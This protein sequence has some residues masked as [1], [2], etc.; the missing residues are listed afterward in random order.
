MKFFILLLFPALFFANI[1]DSNAQVIKDKS[2]KFL[3]TPEE[4]AIINEAEFW[5]EEG[6]YK[7]ALAE[8]MKLENKYPDEQ[9]LIFRIGVCLVNLPDGV[10]ES[11]QYLQRV[12]KNV[13]KK[14]DLEFQLA[15]SLHMNCKFQEAMDLFTSFMN[16]KYGTKEQKTEAKH[17]I[18][19]CKNGIELSKNPIDVKIENIRKPVNTFN[20]EYVPLISSDESH[21]FF[22]YRGIR[23]VGGIQPIK[24]DKTYTSEYFEDIMMS[25]KDSMGYWSEPVLLPENIN[26]LGNDACVAISG[27]AQEMYMFRS[28]PGDEGTLY[29]S[30]LNGTVW[31]DPE[32]LQGKI[33]TE[34]WEGSITIT[35]DGRTAYFSSERPGGKGGRD[36]YSAKLQADG[37]WGN[38]Q[39]MGDAINTR[40]DDD[41]PFIHP[42]G[43]FLVFSSEGHNSIGGYDIFRTE[44]VNDS[45]WGTPVNLGFPLNTPRHDKF[46]VLTANGKYGYYSSGKLGGEGQLDIY[47]VE[48]GITGKKIVLVL[49]KGQVTLN[50]APVEAQIEVNYTN[51][52]VSQGLYRS[53]SAS[54]K[55]LINFAAGKDYTLSFKIPGQEPEVRKLNTQEIESFFESVI[56]VQFYTEE[57]KAR[58]KARKDSMDAVLAEAKEKEIKASRPVTIQQM[59]EKFGEHTDPDLSFR[60]QIG[61]YNL[62]QNFSYGNILKLGKVEKQKLD[63]NITRFTMGMFNNLKAAYEYKNKVVAAGISDAFVTAIYKGKRYLLADLAANNFFVK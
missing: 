37:S 9:V 32:K 24:G 41:A 62:P 51:S 28:I 44:L 59:L 52:G 48:P 56:D 1:G 23:S 26:T 7:L 55:Y 35:A 60:V 33:N 38:I 18:E 63:D 47:R 17:F 34:Y 58:L 2:G 8:Y 43:E 36:I 27:D 4:E 25:V 11:L 49:V 15:R 5:F 19:N 54:G 31:S 57:Y 61:A 20:S 46:Y 16:S 22:T 10:E 6:N 40:F 50:D 12:D 39:N 3:S 29:R 21:L 53:N 42:S 30:Q 14:S 13:F 45:L